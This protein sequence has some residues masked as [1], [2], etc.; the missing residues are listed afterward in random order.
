[1]ALYIGI[2][3]QAEDDES[4][5]DPNKAVVGRDWGNVVYKNKDCEVLAT[6]PGKHL[7]FRGSFAS[8]A[9]LVS[10]GWLH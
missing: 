8:G 4:L 10:P 3:T 1:M 9:G 6:H 5:K 2:S 7:V